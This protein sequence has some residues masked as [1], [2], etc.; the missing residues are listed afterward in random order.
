MV[1][2]PML[3]RC[4][5]S[6]KLI[7]PPLLSCGLD[8]P[9]TAK[10]LCHFAQCIVYHWPRF[11]IRIIP[12]LREAVFNE[13]LATL[14]CIPCRCS[15]VSQPPCVQSNHFQTLFASSSFVIAVLTSSIWQRH[16]LAVKSVNKLE[17]KSSS[18][19][20]C[21]QTFKSGRA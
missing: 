20:G 16:T 18:F 7:A 14:R 17:D 8:R 9:S 12:T 1:I 10:C 11:A 6:C 21:S 2:Q 5:F 13:M 19:P 4:E 3:T 15:T